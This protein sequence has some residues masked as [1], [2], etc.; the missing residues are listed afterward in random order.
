M[1]S[2]IFMS[3]TQVSHLQEVAQ[4]DSNA[5]HWAKAQVAAALDYGHDSALTTFMT[6]GLNVQGLHHCL[7]FMISINKDFHK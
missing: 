3:I 4:N 1:S 5:E 7:P 2:L 6:G